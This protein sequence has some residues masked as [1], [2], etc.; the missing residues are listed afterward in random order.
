MDAFQADEPLLKHF[1]GFLHLP[2]ATAS[3]H[4]SECA[5]ASYSHMMTPLQQTSSD[6]IP[7]LEFRV[8][9]TETYPYPVTVTITLP[10]PPVAYAVEPARLVAHHT[11]QP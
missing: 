4:P 11:E 2:P 3:S 5:R 8:D 9:S 10:G 1:R 7:P 6:P